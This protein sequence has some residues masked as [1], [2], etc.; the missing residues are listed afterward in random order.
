MEVYRTDTNRREHTAM[1]DQNLQLSRE[2]LI[3]HRLYSE[4]ISRRIR[5]IHVG[6]LSQAEFLL[7]AIVLEHDGVQMSELVV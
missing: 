7:L 2:M 3:F 1:S 4:K 5:A 6:A